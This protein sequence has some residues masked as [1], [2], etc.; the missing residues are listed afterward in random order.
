MRCG[1]SDESG[2]PVGEPAWQWEDEVQAADPQGVYDYWKTHGPNGSRE[3][4][5]ID[6]Q[7]YTVHAIMGKRGSQAR[8]TVQLKIHWTG[9]PPTDFTWEQPLKV[10][11]MAP[12]LFSDFVKANMPRYKLGVSRLAVQGVS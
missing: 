4:D 12:E 7:T 6:P 8:G 5:P 1:L 9:Y 2:A 3:P 10:R 11:D